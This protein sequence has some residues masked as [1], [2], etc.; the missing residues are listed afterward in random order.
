M[1]NNTQL[2]RDLEVIAT[3]LQTGVFPENERIS[4]ATEKRF[5][6]LIRQIIFSAA[7][8]TFLLNNLIESL[9]KEVELNQES[10]IARSGVLASGLVIIA[11]VPIS[12]FIGAAF[13]LPLGI[14][15]TPLGIVLAVSGVLLIFVA[16]IIFLRMVKNVFS[17]VQS[18]SEY[19]LI[20][21]LLETGMDSKTAIALS[22]GVDEDIDRALRNTSYLELVREGIALGVPIAKKFKETGIAIDR[23][24]ETLLRKRI[25]TLGSRLLLPLGGLVLPAFIVLVVVPMLL[26]LLGMSF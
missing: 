12:V 16:L 24:Q 18:T 25:Q 21:A 23:E 22:L 14:Y 6:K 26:G 8:T 2:I 5:G 7:P 3:G 4:S 20:A 17:G 11:L 13:G 9:R 15:L 10:K 1:V 19:S